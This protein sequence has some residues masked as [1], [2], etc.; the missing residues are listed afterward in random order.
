MNKIFV[1]VLLF[2]IASCNE[3]DKV[4]EFDTSFKKIQK[5]SFA[6]CLNEELILGRPFF[7]NY[8]DSSLL[9]YDDIDDNLFTL[10]DLN[11][12][13]SIY[14]FGKKGE[15]VNEFLQVFSMCKL[16]DDSSI[17][18]YDVYKHSLLEMNIDN[19]KRGIIEFPLIAKDSLNSVNLY[20]TKYDTKLGIGFY[21]K[22]MLSLTGDSIGSS[23]FFEY[24][25]KDS[26]E[27]LNDNRLRGMA[28]QG[29]MCSNLSLD[30]FVFAV[31]SAPIFFLYSINKDKIEE[32][33]KW[34]GGYPIYRTE[35]TGTVRAAPMSGHNKMAFVSVY[36]TDSYIYLLYSG[37]SFDECNVKAFNGNVIYQ[38]TWMA[39]PVCKYELDTPIT[40]F[41]VSDSDS[42]I[43]ALAD[44][45]EVVLVK[46]ILE[47]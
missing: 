30:K 31:R 45:G 22:N 16:N 14:R 47:K 25:Y 43:Y 13:D 39:E 46:Y 24:P 21:E 11:N 10:I 29:T 33:Y 42:E 12:V 15:G 26:R 35:D 36:A 40:T 32:T 19:I 20:V 27:K 4:R 3:V 44:K 38:M 37:K 28:Y 7:I 8:V 34:F 6:E 2:F 17:G 5:I 18:I 9:I 23:L 1:I 41:C